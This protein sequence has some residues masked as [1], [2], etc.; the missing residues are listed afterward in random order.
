M[1]KSYSTKRSLITSVIALMLCFSMLLGTTFAWFT[2]SVTSANNIITSGNLD[3]EFDYWNGSEWKTVKD[4]SEILANNLWEPGVTEVAYL[5]VTNK[6]SLALKYQLGVNIVSEKAGVNV[7]GQ[8]LKLSDYIY[9]DVAEVNGETEAYA[10][11]EAAMAIATET[12]KISAGY[13]KEATMLKGDA[14]HY[15]A[16]VVYMPETVGNEANHNGTDVPQIDL[17][18]NVLA[19]QVEAELDSFGND[20]DKDS[21]Y[22]KTMVATKEANVA[23]TVN[24]ENVSINIP[25][26][27]PEGDYELT[28]A[29][30]SVFVDKSGVT[31]ANFDIDLTRDGETVNNDGTEFTVTVKVG[32][33]IDASTVKVLHDGNEISVEKVDPVAGTV[34]FKTGSFSPYAIVYSACDMYHDT[35]TNT[36][37]VFTA[38]GMMEVNEKFAA[39]EAGHGSKIK[40]QANID[41]S[42]KVWKTVDSHADRKSSL[43]EIDGQGFVVSNMKINGQAM[44]SRFAGVGNV[45]IKNITFDNADVNSNGKINTSILTVQAYQNVL[46]DNVDVKNSKITGGYKVAPLIATVYNEKETA[47]TATLKN[48]D[49]SNTTVTATSYDF[50]TCGMVAFV[51]VGDNDSIEYENCSVTGVKL[52]ANSGGYNYHANLHYTGSELI[53]EHSGVKVT[54]VTFENL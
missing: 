35:E 16:L 54:N 28:I 2:D 15:L 19:T 22:P 9:F 48:C 40:L 49:V 27:A 51:Y 45:T 53:N 44:F 41:M 24:T 5:R 47:I 23:A 42:G 8:E 36:Y 18:L 43:A 7:A 1:T 50:A 14:P 29:K 11:R 21:T 32:A 37:N 13:S 25:A 4:A 34:T 6:G 52:R 30:S 39:D 33:G 26:G 46:L 20:Y 38:E 17:G 3:V 12:T 31:T 10:N